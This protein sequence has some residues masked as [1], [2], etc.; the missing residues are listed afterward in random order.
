MQHNFFLRRK[1][2]VYSRYNYKKIRSFSRFR[3]SLCV[4]W[5]DAKRRMQKEERKKNS[6][7]KAESNAERRIPTDV[8]FLGRSSTPPK[9]RGPGG[10]APIACRFLQFFNENNTFLGIIRLKFLFKNI[11][12]ISSIMQMV[13]DLETEHFFLVTKIHNEK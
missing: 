4:L 11:F 9:A 7:C 6:Q 3:K 2:L 13:N 10:R 8:E 12:L 1:R 5:A